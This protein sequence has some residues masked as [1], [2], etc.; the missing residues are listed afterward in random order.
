MAKPLKNISVFFV[1]EGS[2]GMPVGQ[3]E[4]IHDRPQLDRINVEL[5]KE[6]DESVVLKTIAITEH[7]DW[8]KE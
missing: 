7:Q 8:P 4:G 6:V 3:D 1:D 2:E 5:R